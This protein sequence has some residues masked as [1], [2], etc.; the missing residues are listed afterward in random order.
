MINFDD[1]VKE[2]IKKHNPN[3]AHIPDHP[4][5]T[6]IIGGAGK[7][8]SL[9][10]LINQLPDIDKIYLYPKDP[11]EAKYQF[12]V[13]KRESTGL[14][15]FN[16]S[17]A[18]TEYPNNMVDIYKNTEDYNSNKKRK[19]L[20]VFDDMIADMLSNRKLNP[21][22]T[23]LFI[24]GRKLN[25][26]LVFITQSYFTVPYNKRLNPTHYFIMKTQSKRK[27]HQITFNHLPD[28]YLKN[29]MNRHIKCTAKQYAFLIIDAT[30][31]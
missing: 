6:L 9:F 15:H 29:F 8:N 31:L 22:V 2:N 13:N 4:Y 11:Y 21:I 18:F 27:L 23:V 7:A 26:S 16:D 10:S 24:S 19:T 30:L 25:I 28:I 20:I 1:V 3:W 14:N 17:K 5:R 12:L